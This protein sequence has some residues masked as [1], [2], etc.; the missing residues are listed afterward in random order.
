MEAKAGVDVRQLKETFGDRLCFM[1]NID[2]LELSKDKKAVEN[3][4]LSKLP[5]AMEGGGY[6]F[7]SDHS[8]PSSV[9]FENY[10]YAIELVHQYGQY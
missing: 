8:V 3:E 1:G 10:Q 2:V 5:V 7:H 4:I 9:C 6:I